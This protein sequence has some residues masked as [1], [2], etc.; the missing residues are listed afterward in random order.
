MSLRSTHALRYRSTCRNL[1]LR[2]RGRSGADNRALMKGEN[3]IQ[4]CGDLELLFQQPNKSK[5]LG[6]G[7]LFQSE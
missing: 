1:R 7:N 6:S 2:G 3:S 5:Q 4:D